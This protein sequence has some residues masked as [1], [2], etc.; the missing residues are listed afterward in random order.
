MFI[1]QGHYEHQNKVFFLFWRE[2]PKSKC[3]YILILIFYKLFK[4]LLLIKCIWHLVTFKYFKICKYFN[5]RW[6]GRVGLRFK[7]KT[8][9]NSFQWNK[10]CSEF[11]SETKSHQE[12]NGIQAAHHTQ[13]FEELH[14]VVYAVHVPKLKYKVRNTEWK[15][16]IRAISAWKGLMWCI[17]EKSE[18]Q[19]RL[20]L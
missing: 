17:A 3:L 5:S 16:Q 7:I 12:T 20:Q 19:C 10:L 9:M 6:L 18:W 2:P 11:A 14:R 13:T 4:N 15:H 8:K 1:S